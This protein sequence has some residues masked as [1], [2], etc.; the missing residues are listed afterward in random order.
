MT[1]LMTAGIFQYAEAPKGEMSLVIPAN[2][3][4]E[5][6]SGQEYPPRSFHFVF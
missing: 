3:S 1:M 2:I 6:N 5:R 4:K